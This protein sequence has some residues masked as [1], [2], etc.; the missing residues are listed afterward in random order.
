M[1]Y[2]QGTQGSSRVGFGAPLKEIANLYGTIPSAPTP[3]T[4]DLGHKET[5]SPIVAQLAQVLAEHLK[6]S[7]E[8]PACGIRMSIPYLVRFLDTPSVAVPSNPACSARVDL[9]GITN[10]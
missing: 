10:I 7:D 2:S 1:A 4:K 3:S 5:I 9:G 8:L 6:A